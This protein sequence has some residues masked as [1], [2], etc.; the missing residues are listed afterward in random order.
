MG[1]GRPFLRFLLFGTASALLVVLVV[2]LWDQL[3]AE[4][5]GLDD[6]EQAEAEGTVL[7][8]ISIRS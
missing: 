8:G 2:R 1:L 7:P 3:T 5:E 6:S 4:T